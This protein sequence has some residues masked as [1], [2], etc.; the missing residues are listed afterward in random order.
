M[1]DMEANSLVR[2]LVFAIQKTR[3][4]L[5]EGL[6]ADS[7]PDGSVVASILE[8]MHP[9]LFGPGNV[10]PRL[11]NWQKACE[12][13]RII[14]GSTLFNFVKYIDMST[15]RIALGLLAVYGYTTIPDD[16]PP[17]EWFA[18]QWPY[19]TA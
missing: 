11:L 16:G 15:S 5:M 12:R 14:E 10:L 13:S 9:L 18:Q 17:I 1:N 3:A 7:S 2:G 4:D 8:D 6:G 19:L